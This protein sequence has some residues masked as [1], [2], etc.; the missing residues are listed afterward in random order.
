MQLVSCDFL[1][2]QQKIRTWF[3]VSVK[4]TI[5]YQASTAK[6][7]TDT[8]G[9]MPKQNTPELRRGMARGSVRY[10][11]RGLTFMAYTMA[12]DVA[13]LHCSIHDP[14]LSIDLKASFSKFRSLVVEDP[15]RHDR[16]VTR[17]SDSELNLELL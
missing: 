10:P 1:C 14:R 8:T 7:A 13:P 4:S 9:A 15:R 2:V 16:M 3:A 6:S 12:N 17:G 11:Y 5:R